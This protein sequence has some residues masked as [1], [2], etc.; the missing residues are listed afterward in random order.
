MF[1]SPLSANSH[2]PSLHTHI[3]SLHTRI[4]SLPLTQSTLE[5]DLRL[6]E[7]IDMCR[8]RSA[9]SLSAAIAHA[10]RHLLPLF[11]TAQ[12][13][14]AAKPSGTADAPTAA[15]A[16]GEEDAGSS[17]DA[18]ETR[19]SNEKIVETVGRAL[20]LLAIAP[21]GWAYEDLYSYTR[22]SK[23]YETLLS[24]ALH[25]H[26]L[27]PQPLLHIALSAGLSSLKVPACY[28]GQRGP[29]GGSSNSSNGN[30]D[31]SSATV[32]SAATAAAAGT[33]EPSAW[34]NPI[35]EDLLYNAEGDT[36]T[37][38]PSSSDEVTK[39]ARARTKRRIAD[40]MRNENC[41][42]CSIAR[43][44]GRGD[45]DHDGDVDDREDAHT[46]KKRG[47]S[48]G[49]GTLAKEVPWS[50]HSNSTIVC[51]ITGKL[52]D[53]SEDGGGGAVVLPN[54]RVYSRSALE[55]RGGGGGDADAAAAGSLDSVVCPRT[56]MTF[57]RSEIKRVY[58]S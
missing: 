25:I 7:F 22:Y 54:G 31:G 15:A 33:G 56:G 11:R 17:A 38:P 13:A 1:T 36:L 23:L 37:S 57:Q 21:G 45:G 27:P 16:D 40:E 53:D 44:G 2:L 28:H 3:S 34:L 42:V 48:L 29:V 9:E 5:F 41:P 26:S 19:R 50:H 20:G 47:I 6:Q 32:A 58:I 30:T 8:N 49:L 51:R 4:S 39:L 14:L 35:D 18:Q 52:I 55:P 43:L 46:E 24:A 10:R 12:E